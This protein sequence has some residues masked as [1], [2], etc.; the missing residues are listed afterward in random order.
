MIA[1]TLRV[2][3]Q[4]V[5]VSALALL[6]EGA[7]AQQQQQ[8]QQQQV[9]TVYSSRSHYGSERVFE[10]FTRETGIK[11]EFFQGNNNEVLERLRSEGRRSRADLLLTVDAG[12]LWFAAQQGLLQP[13][14]SAILARSIPAHLRDPGNQWFAIATRARTIVYSTDRV[15]PSELSTYAALGD[16]KWRGRLCLRTSTAIYN[17]SLLASLIRV[18]G[19]RETER[20]V[21]GWVAN[22]PIYINGDT[23]ILE[24]IAAGRCD[25]GIANHYYLARMLARSPDTPVAVYWADQQ[26]GGTHVNISG[27]GVTRHARNRAGAIRLLEYLTTE[28]AQ[29]VLAAGSYEFPANPSVP[30]NGVLKRFGPF[31]PQSVGVAAA[32]QFQAAAVRLADRAGYR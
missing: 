31:K 5:A 26:G 27:A 1:R 19:E 11:V 22:E 2:R 30:A 17:Q 10:A 4:A 29:S 24:A 20:I 15:D 6:P 18:S 16:P 25:V 32:G 13:V 14:R 23:Q 28:A 12:N 8:Q 21:R 9:V 7:A 3:L